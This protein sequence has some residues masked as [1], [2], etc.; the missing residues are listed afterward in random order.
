M[1]RLL[2]MCI[3]LGGI[4]QL[5]AQVHEDRLIIDK[6]QR[7]A[8]RLETGFPVKVLA[9]GV[10]DKLKADRIKTRTS[11]GL[12]IASGVKIV[13]VGP[14]MMDF[15]FKTEAIGKT[16]SVLFLSVSKGYTNFISPQT[17]PDIWENAV[18]YLPSFLPY[19]EMVNMKQELKAKE[20]EIKS[21]QKAYDK[22]QKALQKQEE[23]LSAA[24]KETEAAQKRLKDAQNEAD[25]LKKKTSRP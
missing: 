6:S 14:E 9:E 2:I 1:K 5:K 16:R 13:E 25:V 8:L 3:A 22:S 19:A 7:P 15:Y 20:K 23:A 11:K 24:R 12:I 4:T 10:A 17:N 21:L 18:L